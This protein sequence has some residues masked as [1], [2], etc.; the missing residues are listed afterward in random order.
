MAAKKSK[1]DRLQVTAPCTADW[2][3]M[4]GNN[5]QRHCAQCDKVVFDF[6]QMTPRQVEA[7]VAVNRGNLC[8]RLT[9]QP[10]GS[11][12]TLDPV[13]ITAATPR[14]V[15]PV[16]SAVVSAILGLSAPVTAQTAAPVQ[17][18]SRF[19]QDSQ[20]GKAKTP[21][22]AALSSLQGTITDPQGAVIA[23]VSVT[24]TNAATGELLNTR[25][26]AEGE[27][28]FSELPPGGYTLNFVSPG[29]NLTVMTGQLRLLA[30]DALY[31]AGEVISILTE[32]L[33]DEEIGKL[34][35]EYELV[36]DAE[37][38]NDPNSEEGRAKRREVILRFLAAVERKLASR[39]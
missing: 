16:A 8:A 19:A 23:N 4:A 36:S 37:D 30:A 11:L 38:G 27:Y 25:S 7:I 3:T 33:D 2:E 35:E 14:R 5:R 29:F 17:I 15:S 18:E 20:K 32:E 6:A 10:D 34:S 13:S 22:G 12:V 1:F 24:L 28:Q 21:T 26:S 9:R 39:N 31:E